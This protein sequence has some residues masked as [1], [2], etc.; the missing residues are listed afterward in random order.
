LPSGN[1]ASLQMEFLHWHLCLWFM[2]VK[3]AA[4]RQ[5]ERQARI[6]SDKQLYEQIKQKNGSN[7]ARESRTAKSKTVADMSARKES[8]GLMHL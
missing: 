7:G 4:E 6:K 5:R 2:K 3:T 1:T 8:I